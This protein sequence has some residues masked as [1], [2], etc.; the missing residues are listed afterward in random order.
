MARHFE[1]K[2]KDRFLI[3]FG[4]SLESV[5]EFAKRHPEVKCDVLVVDGGHTFEIAFSDLMNLKP[6]ANKHTN[7]LILD[8]YPNNENLG[9]V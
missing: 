6:M 8:D 2:Y 1:S 3:T 4:D 7:I 9:K 5:P